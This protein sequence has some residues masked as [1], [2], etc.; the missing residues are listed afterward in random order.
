MTNTESPAWEKTPDQVPGPVTAAER[1]GALDTLR[2]VAVL[3]ILVMNI[4]AFAMPFPA[5]TNPLI[6]GG[7]EWY[8]LGTWFAT[9]VVADQKFMTIFSMMFGAGAVLM[10][11]RAQARDAKLGRIWYRRM[12]WL[13]VIGLVH[14]YL[15]WFGD[16]LV[17]YAVIGML[18]F[19][20]RKWRPRTLVVVA[21]VLL[22]VALLSNYGAYHYLTGLRAEVEDIRALENAGET[23]SE[24]QQA[25][26]E[27][28]QGIGSF[29]SPTPEDIRDEVAAHTGSYA[30][31]LAHRVPLAAGMQV[32]G[33]LFF[34]IWRVGALM[35]IGMALM[36][37]G[38]LTGQAAD[39]T[40][41]NLVLWGYGLGL[42]LVVYSC[43]DLYAQGFD[44][45]YVLKQG[46][47]ANYFAS[48][49]V[50]LGHIGLVMTLVRR[51][52]VRRLME[53]F[54]AVGRMAFTN[55]LMHSIVM[56]T[57]FYGYGFGLY[58]EIPRAAQMLFVAGMIGFQLWLSP[59]W[60][61]RF[62][63]GPAEWLWRSLT[64]WQLPPMRA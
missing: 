48:I 43:F 38:I 45:L 47:I 59:W 37:L 28:W 21:C 60:L 39:S 26:L 33:L 62:R 42:P 4:Y 29:M 51:G 18:V 55:Y 8:N 53:R 46:G 40:Y 30:D 44:G 16:I 19:P 32:Q 14:A 22:P 36:K 9:H 27:E 57:I 61:A 49:L 20:A 5:Y 23:L 58:G 12:F 3:G 56:T 7:E 1:F 25:K 13:L 31:L 41:R 35:L 34:M 24:E 54:A 11:E 52:L 6:M 64:Y 17:F 15:V 50:A 2:G 63:F 10:W